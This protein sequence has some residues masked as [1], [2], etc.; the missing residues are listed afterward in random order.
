MAVPACCRIWFFVSV[1]HLRGHVHVADAAT[2]RRSG[3]PGRSPTLLERVLEAVLDRAERRA[4]RATPTSI[5]ASIVADRRRQSTGVVKSPTAAAQRDHA[6]RD[7]LAVVGADLERHRR[8]ASFSSLMPLNF[9]E[10]PMRSISEASW[11]TSDW[12]A[13]WSVVAERAVL[14]LHGQLTD[15]LEHRVDLVEAPSAV[16]TSETPSW[17][18]R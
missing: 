10:S 9:A 17:M 12:I 7:H 1:D 3:S 4:R 2:R 14:V 5:A 18:L 8:R 15:A 6:D 13:A 16:C 11:L